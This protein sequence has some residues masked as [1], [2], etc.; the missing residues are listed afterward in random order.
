MNP[1]QTIM[2]D[3]TEVGSFWD[4]DIT[5]MQVWSVSAVDSAG[6]GAGELT[7]TRVLD[8]IELPYSPSKI[9]SSAT[10]HAYGRGDDNVRILR[11][12]VSTEGT[13]SARANIFS[14]NE[15]EAKTLSGEPI[16]IAVD[17][18]VAFSIDLTNAGDHFDLDI[19]TV[20]S[21]MSAANTASWGSAVVEIR[22]L[23]GGVENPYPTTK[24]LTSTAQT[25]NEES[26][27][28]TPSVRFVVTTSDANAGS[29]RIA[30]YGSKSRRSVDKWDGVACIFA[31][32]GSNLSTA[33]AGGFQWSYGNGDTAD[34]FGISPPFDYEI[35]A[36]SLSVRSNSAGTATVA[37][38][39]GSST[40]TTSSATGVTVSLASGQRNSLTVIDNPVQGNR[41]DWITFRTTASAGGAINGGRVSTWIRPR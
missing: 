28:N 31:E 27:G 12:T 8:G 24:E 38:Y 36:M 11:I 5:G 2:L 40:D 13:G 21:W 37:V 23:I 3:L 14:A 32:E 9:L 22:R 26:D 17:Q 1:T 35:L 4:I 6:W 19:S 41:G 34:G 16:P 7:I 20:G 15:N 39:S 10:P 29:G 30:I 25:S 33:T 18:S